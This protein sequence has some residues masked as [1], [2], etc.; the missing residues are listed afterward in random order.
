M[1]TL[2]AEKALATLQS[3]PI[4]GYPNQIPL[5][6]SPYPPTSPPTPLP[7][8]SASSR[9]VKHLPPGFSDSLLY[10]LF[11]PYGALSSAHAQTQFGP[12]TGIV[13][14]WNEDDARRAESDMHMRD[15]QGYTIAVQIY[16]PRRAPSGADFNTAAPAFI[17]NGSMAPYS[18]QV[19]PNVIA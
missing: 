12:E 5:V 10:D 6:L 2:L 4:P 16:V 14:F 7:P 13:E 18:P 8:P 9:L 3:R 19:G 1:C 15:I 11:R 17:P